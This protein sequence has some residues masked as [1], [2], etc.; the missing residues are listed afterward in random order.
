MKSMLAK[1]TAALYCAGIIIG[2]GVLTLPLAA[3]A[4]GFVPLLTVVFVVGLGLACVYVRIARTANSHIHAIAGAKAQEAARAIRA[5][6]NMPTDSNFLSRYMARMRAVEVR[7]GLRIFVD[8][9]DRVGLGRAGRSAFSLGILCYVFPADIAYI[10]LGKTSLTVAADRLDG[11]LPRGA[12]AL[13]V[14]GALLSISCVVL[15][16]VMRLRSARRAAL[17]KLLVMATCWLWTLALLLAVDRTRPVLGAASLAS[18]LGNLGFL[19]AVLSS[20][21]VAAGATHEAD[22]DRGLTAAHRVAVWIVV[23]ELALLVIAGVGSIA[24]FVTSGAHERFVAFAPGWLTFARLSDFARLLGVVLFAYVGTGILNLCQYEFLFRPPEKGR[25]PIVTVVVLGSL[26]PLAAYVLWVITAALTLS[27]QDLAAA[28][29]AGE[30]THLRIAAK[31]ATLNPT[32]GLMIAIAGSLFALMAV[33]SACHGFTETLADRVGSV[34]GREAGWWG[35]QFV[36]RPLI[37]VAASAVATISDVVGA[38]FDITSILG[39]A[40]NAGGGLL[41]LILPFFF[42]YPLE[43]RRRARYW[44]VALATVIGLVVATLVLL[45]GATPPGWAGIVMW[46]AKGLVALAV[47]GSVAW[48][49]FSEPPEQASDGDQHAS[50]TVNGAGFEERSRPASERV[51]AGGG[52][53][54]SD[55]AHGKE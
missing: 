4:V 45:T 38:D 44:E 15:A 32:A 18:L 36:I 31:A 17:I 22:S 51:L 1:L 55:H 11:R 3:K 39:L 5:G 14:A 29:S 7:K 16:K 6:T 13:F 24:L 12:L 2:A 30:G 48:L 23:V 46:C 50:S 41:I 25:A 53:A 43:R 35:D 19:V 49:L 37:L 9:M 20:L 47:L 10:L 40:G 26:I 28:D 52:M 21:Y 54:S 8:L 34:L 42:P 27:P 33:T